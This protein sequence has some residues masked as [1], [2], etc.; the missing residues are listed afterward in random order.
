MDPK[1]INALYYGINTLITNHLQATKLGPAQRSDSCRLI[2]ILPR[3]TIRNQATRWLA[4]T[5]RVPH[6]VTQPKEPLRV[7]PSP[8]GLPC[9]ALPPTCTST[10]LIGRSSD[11]QFPKAQR[12][13][14]LP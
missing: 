2:Y 12:L 10:P 6:R 9:S 7:T 4:V 14:Q 8:R 11:L 1:L 13:K 5:E 3:K